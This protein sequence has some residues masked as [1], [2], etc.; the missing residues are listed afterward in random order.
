[1]P[2]PK[3]ISIYIQDDNTAT[4][5]CPKCGKTKTVD[6][7]EYLKVNGSVKVKYR[8]KCD[9]CDCGKTAC[10]DCNIEDCRFGNTTSVV[11]E[12]RRQFR[13]PVKLHGICTVKERNEKISV[14]I[15][16]ISRMGLKFKLLRS[17]TLKIG[18]K[19][20]VQFRLDDKK[21]TMI[22]K[23]AVVKKADGLYIGVEFLNI[24]PYDPYDR[25]L[26]FYML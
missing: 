14:L 17:G 18:E 5:V 11:L 19:I 3:P 12:R 21:G 4:F 25:A 9:N 6:V 22:N 10:S 15:M 24:D 2:E 23:E 1:M 7:S 8:F 13:K 20:T 16:D 26:G